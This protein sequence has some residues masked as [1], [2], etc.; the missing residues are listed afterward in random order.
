MEYVCFFRKSEFRSFVMN[1]RFVLCEWPIFLFFRDESYVRLSRMI[2]F[3]SFAMNHKFNLREWVNQSYETKHWFV[4]RDW[5][6]CA[7]LQWIIGL[8]W[9]WINFLMIMHIMDHKFSL[10]CTIILIRF[11]AIGT[12]HFVFS[13]VFSNIEN[14][15]DEF[16]CLILIWIRRIFV[17]CILL[18]SSP[19]YAMYHVTLTIN[20]T[21]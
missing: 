10:K 21:K 5:A 3:C 18:V 11:R 8:S 14:D 16:H 4:I 19:K 1:H 13:F 2:M 20:T 17:S 6:T 9:R 7:L 15:Y 12:H